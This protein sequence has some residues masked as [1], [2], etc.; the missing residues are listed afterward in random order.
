MKWRSAP[1]TPNA[2]QSGDPNRRGQSTGGWDGCARNTVARQ[3]HANRDKD[4]NFDDAS[5]T[6]QPAANSLAHG[7]KR[8]DQR[9]ARRRSRGNKPSLS[10][11]F[12]DIGPWS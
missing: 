4:Q 8:A 2:V 3:L 7:R 11:A 12:A 9:A 1:A 6:V 5:L 10:G